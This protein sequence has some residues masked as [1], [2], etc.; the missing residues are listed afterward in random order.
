MINVCASLRIYD[1]RLDENLLCAVI[2]IHDKIV[3]IVGMATVN[4]R[5]MDIFAV[6]PMDAVAALI[7][8]KI[9]RKRIIFTARSA[10]HNI[11]AANSAY[12]R[13]ANTELAEAQSVFCPCFAVVVAYMIIQIEFILDVVDICNERA[14]LAEGHGAIRT[15]HIIARNHADLGKALAA[16]VAC[17]ESVAILWLAGGEVDSVLAVAMMENINHAVANKRI[18]YAAAEG[19]HF[20]GR[21]PC[22]AAILGG[23]HVGRQ[24]RFP[25]IGICASGTKSDDLIL[26]NGN[27]LFHAEREAFIQ[28]G[29]IAVFETARLIPCVA[30]IRGSAVFNPAEAVMSAV[31]MTGA[32][33]IKRDHTSLF[34]FDKSMAEMTGAAVFFVIDKK[35][36]FTR[37]A[38]GDNFVLK[39]NDSSF[40]GLILNWF[41]TIIIQDIAYQNNVI[42]LR[43]YVKSNHIAHFDLLF[44]AKYDI[45]MIKTSGG[46]MEKIERILSKPASFY[47]DAMQS[48]LKLGLANRTYTENHLILHLFWY[49]YIHDIPEN[50]LPRYTKHHSHSCVELHCIMGGKYAYHEK[51]RSPVFLSAGDF[52]LIAPHIEHQLLQLTE[53]A[54]TITIAFLL[55]TEITPEGNVLFPIFETVGS[56]SEKITPSVLQL[57]EMIWEEAHGTAHFCTHTIPSYIMIHLLSTI[58]LFEASSSNEDDTKWIEPACA[59]IENYISDN[60]DLVFSVSKLA[61]HLHLSEKQ[62]TR[63]IQNEYHTTPK[64]LIDS[65]KIRQAKKLLIE[66]D[67][68]LEQIS[69]ALGFSDHNNFNRFFK[70][71]EGLPPGIFR[72]SKGK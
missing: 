70:R 24:I 26:G 64:A 53:E 4:L 17:E 59:D 30:V 8:D 45:L 27:R 43:F 9:P 47:E 52:I 39:H 65:I 51:D 48:L 42:F 58:R 72:H 33:G 66:S 22:F 44:A 6:I 34:I 20:K 29:I 62:L 38:F 1:G 55:K 10:V 2:L 37:N 40:L 12:L 69:D 11:T 36:A 31:A 71:V 49:R 16:V 41:V 3:G 13:I 18:I 54:E 14:V 32:I 15:A 7:E 57:I 23:D 68:T 67:M 21:T 56:V 19:T 46:V 28:K 63:I 5:D 50:K 25:A 35:L 60:S 61:E